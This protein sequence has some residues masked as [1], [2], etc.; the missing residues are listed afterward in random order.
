MQDS[1]Q[2]SG[3]EPMI[4]PSGV[5]AWPPA[6]GWYGAFAL[7]LL[8]LL[9]LTIRSIRNWRQ[10]EYRR[11]ALKHLAMINPVDIAA[12]NQVLKITA[13]HHYTRARVASL[14]GKAWLEFLSGS[15]ASTDFTCE[16]LNL[17]GNAGFLESGKVNI[18]P[19]Q[20]KVLTSA[21]EVWIRKH[22]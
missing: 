10:N 7:V 8:A 19:Y 12:V 15:C 2:I 6:P 18:S 14:S 5:A 21:A 4:S 3:L 20:W 16:P 22:H 9:I 11:K 17:L 1:I 13:M